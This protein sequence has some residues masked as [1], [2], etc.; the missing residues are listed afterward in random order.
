MYR[1]Q[2]ALAA[3]VQIIPAP[4]PERRVPERFELVMR[5]SGGGTGIYTQ[6]EVHF[7]IHHG[8]PHGVISFESRHRSCDCT[9]ARVL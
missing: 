1:G 6:N 7:P 9:R 4:G 3:T 8:K 5:A 2:D